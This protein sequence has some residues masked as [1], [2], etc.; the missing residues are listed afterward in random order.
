MQ[1]SGETIL[2]LRSENKKLREAVKH[3]EQRIVLLAGILSKK[4]A[5]ILRLKMELEF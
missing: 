2:R 3:L 4:D 5:E 1:K